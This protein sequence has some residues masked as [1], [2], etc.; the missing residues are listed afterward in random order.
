MAADAD[1]AFVT[2]AY[3]DSPFLPDCLRSLAR[4]TVRARVL[5][6]TSTPSEFIHRTAEEFG[7]EVLVNPRRDGIGADWNFALGAAKASGRLV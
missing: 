6:T 7:A 3:G 2:P 5:V 1:H 4:Q